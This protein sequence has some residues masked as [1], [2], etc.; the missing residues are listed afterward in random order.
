MKKGLISTFVFLALAFLAIT[1]SKYAPADSEANSESTSIEEDKKSEVMDF[2]NAYQKATDLRTSGEYLEAVEYYEVALKINPEHQDALYYLGNMRLALEN[3]AGAE[4][5]W[6]KLAELNPASA[7]AH[8]QLG[9]LYSCP[10]P[11]NYLYG[12]DKAE[13]QFERASTLNREETGPLLQLAKISLAKSET[14]QAGKQLRDVVASNFRSAEA[15]FLQGYIAWKSGNTQEAT[16]HLIE[17][18]SIIAGSSGK[19]NVGEGA[20][21]KSSSTTQSQIIQCDPYS[22][23]FNRFILEADENGLKTG[24]I[25]RQFNDS[26]TSTD[27]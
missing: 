18:H 26:L 2:W 25:Y 11:N 16:R 22:A 4:K 27:R 1:Y 19:K 23:Y 6:T 24:H 8:S 21:K 13:I 9:T 17:S 5:V 7:R 20:T 15:I 14:S 3:Y 12:L 10:D